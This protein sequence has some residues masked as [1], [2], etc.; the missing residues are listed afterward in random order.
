MKKDQ[1]A[2]HLLWQQEEQA[3]FQGWD[4]SRLSGRWQE[5][6]LPWDY[7]AMVLQAL[8]PHA[9][10]LDMG[11]GGGEFLLS[12]GHP[13]ALTCA[14][15]GYPPN[16]LLCEQKLSPLGVT[17]KEVAED[18]ILPFPDNS[19]DL[20]INRHES[21]D[22][23]EVFRCLRQ[24]GRFITQQVGARNNE[25][26][27]HRLIADYTPA[28]PNHTLA[29][30]ESMLQQAGFDIQ[31][32]QEAYPPLRFFDVGAIVYFA[33]IIEWE[34]PGFSV[35]KCFD[36]L[37]ALQAEMARDGFVESREHRFVVVCRKPVL[38]R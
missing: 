9:R 21:F 37:L 14:T 26:L 18:D 8:T 36:R 3:A 29:H 25:S 11:T 4:F 15:E 34:F 23:A 7:R 27:S 1:D 33:K 28:Y 31:T 35:D 16:L 32:A 10:L 5:G 38:I 2:L 12:L 19:F 22:A 30:N 17:V 6:E 20:I 13:P 24:E